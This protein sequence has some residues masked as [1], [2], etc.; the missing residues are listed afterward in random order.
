MHFKLHSWL[1][2]LN[3][4]MA[5]R[6]TQLQ[7]E[8]SRFSSVADVMLLQYLHVTFSNSWRRRSD[9]SIGHLFCHVS[10]SLHH[11]HI[12]ITQLP[13][14]MRMDLWLIT[15]SYHVTWNYHICWCFINNHV[16]IWQWAVSVVGSVGINSS[17]VTLNKNTITKNC[18]S[19]TFFWNNMVVLKQSTFTSICI[20]VEICRGTPNWSTDLSRVCC[21]SS[22]CKFSNMAVMTVW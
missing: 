11:N 15:H 4:E 12:Y 21:A 5:D 2:L 16:K 3:A 18:Y 17:S 6:G 7:V 14:V 22:M 13:E 20:P 10:I 1:I 8:I 9:C 19:C